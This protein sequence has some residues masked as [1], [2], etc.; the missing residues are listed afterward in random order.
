MNKHDTVAILDFGAIN[1]Q[2][3][4][5]IVRNLNVYCEVLPCTAPKARRRFV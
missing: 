4:A 1:S 5:K 2:A 3:A